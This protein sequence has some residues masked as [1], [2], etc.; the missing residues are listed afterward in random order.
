M[1]FSEYRKNDATALA[2]L[3][4]KRS[5]SPAELLELAVDRFEAVNDRLNAVVSTRLPAARA[6]VEGCEPWG[7]FSGVPFL[8]KDLAMEIKGSPMSCGSRSY[9]GYVSDHDSDLVAAARRSGLIVFGKTNTPEFGITPYTEP[10]ALGPARNPW[11]TMH[12]PGGSSGG[13]GAAVAAGIVP[14]ASASDGGGSIRIPASN[15]GLFGLKSSR[16]LL[17]FA[18]DGWGGGVVEGCLSRSVRDTA[19]YLD[20]VSGSTGF[21]SALSKGPPEHLRIAFSTAH[22]FADD[23]LTVHEDCV[24]A[25]H[26]AMRLAQ[27]LGHHVEEVSLPWDKAVYERDFLP[28]LFVSTVE[29]VARARAVRGGKLRARDLEPNTA[30]MAQMGSR[31]DAAAYTEALSRWTELAAR[32]AA[33][34]EGFD[35][36]CV[37]SLAE[38]PA[39]IGQFASPAA[40]ALAVRA[41]SRLGL[42]GLLMRFGIVREMAQRVFGYMPFTP[43][44]NMA[45]LPAVSLPLGTSASGLPV[46]VQFIGPQ[47]SDELLLRFSAAVETSAPWFDRVP[48]L[49]DRTFTGP[50]SSQ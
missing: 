47:G 9:R 12:T 42:A 49:Q 6:E 18:Q 31:I 35:L 11:N 29:E 8:L 38:P 19:G 4:K 36:L 41:A 25:V 28:V 22:P 30:L 23:G 50:W 37:P 17:P 20:A 1:T 7:P 26:E 33:V 14:M 46:G 43:P 16:G 45:G 27:S 3:V 24:K 44:A 32:F 15:C 39:R 21:V 5:V 10:S 40:E 13:S 48:E 34:Y 2:A